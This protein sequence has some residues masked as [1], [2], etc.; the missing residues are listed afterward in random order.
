M[1]L[2]EDNVITIDDLP[3]TTASGLAIS[4][5]TTQDADEASFDAYLHQSLKQARQA[6]IRRFE[7]VYLTRLLREKHGRVGDV[8]QAADIDVRTLF[9]KMKCYGLSKEDYK[10]IFIEI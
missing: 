5:A 3:V 10:T 1:L 9:D 2:C 7:R 4:G 6:L 8:A